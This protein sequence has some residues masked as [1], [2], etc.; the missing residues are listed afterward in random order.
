LD[1]TDY[2]PGKAGEAQLAWLAKALDARPD[3]PAV[4]CGHHDPRLQEPPPGK[5]SWS[6]LDWPDL[7]KVLEPRRQ[8]KM[9]VYGHTHVWAVKDHPSGIHLVNLPPVA[10]VFA[11][12]QPSGWVHAVLRPDGAK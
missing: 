4:V 12:G 8:V 11:A 5:Q 7:L 9:Y 1:V 2:P 3:K 6:L 10:Y